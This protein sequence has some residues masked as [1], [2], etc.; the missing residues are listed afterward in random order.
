M[1][2]LAFLARLQETIF[3]RMKSIQ[4]S[5]NGQETSS[6][7]QPL[8]FANTFGKQTVVGR[9]LQEVEPKV[10]AGKSTSVASP[11]VNG[12]GTL[13]KADKLA[14]QPQTTALSKPTAH[15]N[16][17]SAGV[18]AQTSLKKVCFMMVTA[19]VKFF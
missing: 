7:H 1:A 6:S 17:T 18:A 15:V 4:C 19:F 16:D 8:L 3:Q 13:S 12:A 5:V 9:S 11:M 2:I 14:S 10:E